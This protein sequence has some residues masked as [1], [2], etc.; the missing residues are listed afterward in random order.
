MTDTLLWSLEAAAKQL[1]GI[2]TRAVRRL[3]E[4]GDIEPCHVG[5][6]LLVSVASVRSYVDRM[7]PSAQNPRGAGRMCRRTAHAL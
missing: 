5:G 7:R 4:A 6:R 2:S 3:L 1:G